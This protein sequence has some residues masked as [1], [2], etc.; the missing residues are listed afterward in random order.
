MSS[1]GLGIGLLFGAAV[2]L[3]I[4]LL[5]APRPGQE[6]REL[7]KERAQEIF[8]KLKRSDNGKVEAGSIHP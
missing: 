4:G 1:K 6:T 8:G 5:Y 2:G 3:V 7:V